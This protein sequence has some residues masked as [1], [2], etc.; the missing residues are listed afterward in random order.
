MVEVYVDSINNFR[1]KGHEM[2]N[3]WLNYDYFF[4]VDMNF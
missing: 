3:Y 2:F 1:Q 4:T